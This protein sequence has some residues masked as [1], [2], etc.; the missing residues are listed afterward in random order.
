VIEF[1]DYDLSVIESDM[2]VDESPK[3]KSG[4]SSELVETELVL[5]SGTRIGHR[6]FNV[7]YRQSLRPMDVSTH[8][9]GNLKILINPLIILFSCRHVRALLP[10][11][12]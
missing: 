9:C 6:S 11:D 12:Y 1:Y 3:T 8:S 7:Y 2:D 10:I 4:Q 5:P